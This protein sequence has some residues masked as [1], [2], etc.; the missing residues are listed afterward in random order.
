MID[1]L[2]DTSCDVAVNTKTIVT[3]TQKQ[4]DEELKDIDDFMEGIVDEDDEEV[5][6]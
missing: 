5:E 3:L 6:L 2:E 4:R 1:E